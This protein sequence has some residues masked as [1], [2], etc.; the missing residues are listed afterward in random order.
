[1]KYSFLAA[2]FLCPALLSAAEPSRVVS[3]APSVTELM[4]AIGEGSHLVGDTRYCDY[5]EAALALPKVGGIQDV[6]IEK[7]VRLKPDLVVASRTGNS[8][9]T[10][11]RLSGLGIRTLVLSEYRVAD[12]ASNILILGNV[13]GRDTR[14]LADAWT[15]RI[16]KLPKPV[17]RRRTMAVISIAPIYSASTDTF[18]GD[19]L[20]L[21]GFSNCVT[22]RTAYPMI[23]IEELARLSPEIL[24]V[25]DALRKEEQALRD[26]LKQAGISP[27][28][29]W[30]DADRLSRPA[31]RMM[32]LVEKLAAEN[33]R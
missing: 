3:L 23:P 14:V 20:E 13:M 4:F 32:D 25:S 7:V 18:L 19:A 17:L 10:V 2:F 30:V 9:E 16:A 8:R 1:M 33:A 31:P 24:L 29:R 28:I 27:A 6:D 5:P 15:A 22:T 26:V 11:E 21:A 12:I